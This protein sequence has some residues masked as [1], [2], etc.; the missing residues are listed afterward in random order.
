MQYFMTRSF[1]VKK[2]TTNIFHDSVVYLQ[3]KKRFSTTAVFSLY[4]NY[5]EF[6][7]T[8]IFLQ[9][10][11]NKFL[12]THVILL[13]TSQNT[14]LIN[15][16]I[17]KTQVHKFISNHWGEFRTLCTLEMRY[18]LIPSCWRNS[19]NPSKPSKTMWRA[20]FG[21]NIMKY[22]FHLTTTQ[23]GDEGQVN[24]YIDIK[25]DIHMNLIGHTG[26]TTGIETKHPIGLGFIWRRIQ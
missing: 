18:G 7:D 9:T 21:L 12:T 1:L 6:H 5:G 13:F 25:T 4:K 11:R 8:V 15:L 3:K 14:I 20:I 17:I 24:T 26:R 2:N 19:V 22:T 16:E 10:Q 23:I